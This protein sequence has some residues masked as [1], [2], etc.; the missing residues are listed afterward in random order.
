MKIV[1][2]NQFKNDFILIDDYSKDNSIEIIKSIK[3]INVHILKATT[4]ETSF[5]NSKDTN[6]YAGISSLA[7]NIIKNFQRA[8]KFCLEIYGNDVY[9][10]FFDVDE[11]LF[12]PEYPNKKIIEIIDNNFDNKPVLCVGSLEVDSDLFDL[13]KEWITQQTTR[14]MSFKTKFEGTRR[15]TVKSF[16]NLKYNDLSIFYNIP[17]HLYGHHIH[18]GGVEP[19]NCNFLPLETCAFL[20]FRKPMYDPDINRK[21]CNTNYELVKQISDEAIKEIR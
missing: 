6:A 11:F 18:H 5:E 17:I 20:H 21:L 7:V 13:N 10:G 9:L 3:D 16:Q 15:E 1:L 2:C 4:P 8:H 14:G 19:K 12:Y